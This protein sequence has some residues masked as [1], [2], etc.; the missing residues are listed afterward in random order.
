VAIAY[1]HG[2]EV[3]ELSSRALGGD[4]SQGLREALQEVAGNEAA[5]AE[6]GRMGES[7]Y[8]PDWMNKLNNE[9]GQG[10]GW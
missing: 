8:G 7:D 9:V 5:F 3:W 6:C 4:A 10:I 2:R 1:A